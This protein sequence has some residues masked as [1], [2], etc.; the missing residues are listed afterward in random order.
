MTA[1]DSTD[2]V[3]LHLSDCDHETAEVVF[4]ALRASFSD[5]SAPGGTVRAA[6]GGAAATV[7]SLTVDASARTGSD[8]APAELGSP[9]TAELYGS[10]DQ[11]RRVREELERA[12]VTQDLGTVPGEH[13]VESR[14]RLT[15]R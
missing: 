13:E 6:G 12:F 10:A 4:D 3:S 1:E 14:L 15:G 2:H 5:V 8:P 9:V 11:V 7:W